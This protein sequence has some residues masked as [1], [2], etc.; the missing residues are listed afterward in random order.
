MDA[1][2][3]EQSYSI[4]YINYEAEPGHINLDNPLQMTEQN[5]RKLRA[6]KK[7][8]KKKKADGFSVTEEGITEVMGTLT[9]PTK[10]GA[11]CKHDLGFLSSETNTLILKFQKLFI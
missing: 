9:V 5:E 4:K 8:S 6:F 11:R 3:W 2:N 7:S 10:V 1:E